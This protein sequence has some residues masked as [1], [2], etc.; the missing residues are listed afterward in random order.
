MR[1]EALPEEQPPK[2][3]TRYAPSFFETVYEKHFGRVYT[4]VRYVVRDSHAAD[5]IVS[6]VFVKVLRKLNGYRP[7]KGTLTDWLFAIARNAV[8]DYLRSMKHRSHLSLEAIGEK[9]ASE[10]TPE[11]RYIRE[12]ALDRLI[13]ALGRLGARER[14]IVALRFAAGLSNRSIARMCALSEGNVAVI[15]YRAVRRLQKDLR[16]EEEAG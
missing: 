14:E 4:F 2:M 7:Q 12:E 16:D 13:K 3:H 1:A 10:P 15:I 6:E 8:R 11:E 5:D 9:A